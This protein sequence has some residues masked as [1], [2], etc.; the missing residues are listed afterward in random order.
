[1]EQEPGKM[2]NQHEYNIE[3]VW[4]GS[5]EGPTTSY[6]GYSREYL[7]S[8]P[9]KPDL[10]GTADPIFRGDPAL[11]NPEDLLV[12]ALST[13]HM[14][15]Y[16]AI[17]ARAGLPVVSYSDKATG[18]MAMKE[19]QIRFTDVLLRPVVVIGAGADLNRASLFHSEAHHVCFI[20]NSVNFPV[21]HEAEMS[22][23]A[24]R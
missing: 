23:A 3:T 21:R 12:A 19:G 22:Q 5:S 6:E 13:C 18:I 11:H 9:G 17:C 4:T 2:S 7:V 15:S 14:L 24:G 1:M 10:R 8:I 20:A 16:L